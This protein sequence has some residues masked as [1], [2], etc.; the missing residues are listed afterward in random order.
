MLP[1]SLLICQCNICKQLGRQKRRVGSRGDWTYYCA[2]LGFCSVAG[3]PE[4]WWAYLSRGTSSPHQGR[5]GLGWGEREG[6]GEE[7]ASLL[8]DLLLKHTVSR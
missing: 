2:A 3:I 8:S 6:D 5:E 1:F 4:S 7:K